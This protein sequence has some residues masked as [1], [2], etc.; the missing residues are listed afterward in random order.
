MKDSKNILIAALVVSAVVLTGVLVGT[1]VGTGRTAQAGE[2]SRFW[3][4]TGVT[5][6]VA[7]G[8]SALYL[9]DV[10]QQRLNVYVVNQKTGAIDILE[11][12]DLAKVFPK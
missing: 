5:A 6:E 12:I 8:T 1:F 10:D 7:Q 9:I 11:T 2:F 3:G 4:M